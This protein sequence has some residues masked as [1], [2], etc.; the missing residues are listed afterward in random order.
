MYN[1]LFSKPFFD[2]FNAGLFHLSLENGGLP[3]LMRS[4]SS[5]VNGLGLNAGARALNK[6]PMATAARP[7]TNSGLVN[8]HQTAKAATPNSAAAMNHIQRDIRP[9]FWTLP[10]TQRLQALQQRPQRR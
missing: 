8:A 3:D 4:I 6:A 9:S 5:F 7:A 10:T 1:F 2:G